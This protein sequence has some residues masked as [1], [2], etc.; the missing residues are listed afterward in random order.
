MALELKVE[1]RFVGIS[2][3]V[4]LFLVMDTIII[5]IKNHTVAAILD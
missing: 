3:K 4:V 5:S 1:S 2:V